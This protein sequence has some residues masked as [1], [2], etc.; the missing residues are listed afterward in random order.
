MRQATWF[1]LAVTVLAIGVITFW[2]TPVDAPAKDT[3]REVLEAL[4][5]AGVPAAVNYSFVEIAANV[6]MFVPLGAV[7]AL[8]LP[9]QHWWLAVLIAGSLSGLIELIQ[10]LLLPHRFASFIDIA[11]NTT[12]ALIGVLVIAA[13]HL[14]RHRWIATR[15]RI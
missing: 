9:R 7:L 10:L 13:V 6:A 12:G 5:Y 11:A 3:I 8:L 15:E 1:F 4:H 2:P 14:G